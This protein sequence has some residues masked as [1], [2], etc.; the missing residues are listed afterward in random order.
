LPADCEA[1]HLS[2]IHPFPNESLKNYA[3]RLAENINVNEKFALVGLSLGG[4]I[5]TEISHHLNAE[6]TILISSIPLSEQMPS[7]YK[8]AA[9][10]QVHKFLPISILKSLS[11]IKR[12]FSYE[13]GDD[14]KMLMM[15]IKETDPKFIRW[16]IKAALEWRNKDLPQNLYHLHGTSDNVLPMKRAKPGYVISK[17]RHLMVLN[18]SKEI[19]KLME[20]I[21]LPV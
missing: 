12:I 6:K 10:L 9:V 16:A 3:I 15:M 21:L 13:N 11:K 17:G 19:N 18:R 5:A 14:K 2:W 7:H 4:M 1:V 8:L 20:E